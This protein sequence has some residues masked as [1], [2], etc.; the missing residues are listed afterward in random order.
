MCDGSIS[1]QQVW[2]VLPAGGGF[3]DGLTVDAEGF[4]WSAHWDG[5]CIARYAPDGSL[6]RSIPLPVSR[7]TSL[8]FAGPNLD[9]LVITLATI[10]LDDNQRAAEPLAGKVLCMTPGVCGVP[11]RRYRGF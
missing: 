11:A 1:R 7:P 3:P 8:T 5:G 6:E 10:G 9:Q 4:V 2:V